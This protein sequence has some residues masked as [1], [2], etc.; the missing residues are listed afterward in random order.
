MQAGTPIVAQKTG[1]LTRQV[2]DHRDGSENGVALPVEF[3]T[4]VGS[5]MVPYIHE[6]YVSADTVSEGIMKM[7]EMSSDDKEAL[8]EKVMSYV[9]S[10][11]NYQDMIDEWDKV[12]WEKIHNWKDEYDRYKVKTY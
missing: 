2:V 11:F 7:Y 9:K 8:S 5:Q 6:D 12:L 1:G 4:L 3:K 10:E